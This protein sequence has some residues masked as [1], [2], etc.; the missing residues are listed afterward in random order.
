MSRE[1]EPDYEHLSLDELVD[2]ERW[3]NREAYPERY[4]RLRAA[5]ERRQRE[6]SHEGLE[7]PAPPLSI[8]AVVIGGIREGVLHWRALLQALIVPA[9]LL[10]LLSAR[11]AWLAGGPWWQVT[12]IF[13][14]QCAVTVI[15]VV[16]CHRIVLLGE[17]SLPN[18][19]GVYW[20]RREFRFVGWSIVTSLLV[21]P[22]VLPMGAIF[23]LTPVEGI[24]EESPWLLSIFVYPPVAY[25]IS[26]ASLLF[27]L[28]A[29]DRRPN[30]GEAWRLSRDNGWRLTIALNVPWLLIA[31]IGRLVAWATPDGLVPPVFAGLWLCLISA[32][33]VTVLS[34]AYRTLA[35]REQDDAVTE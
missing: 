3:I 20:T 34:V 17:R 11:D 5:I 2:I 26:R 31:A 16:S 30:L 28:T 12:G 19:F 35:P 32:V 33:E 29:I 18:R 21:V 7:E 22:V 23:A 27:P 15:Y 9:A 1:Q 10:T 24:A 14:L 25:V 13:A 6:A 8:R 4:A